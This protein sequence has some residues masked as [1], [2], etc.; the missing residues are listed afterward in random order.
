MVHDFFLEPIRKWLGVDPH[1]GTHFGA[2]GT[3]FTKFCT[4]FIKFGTSDPIAS[5]NP[6]WT[7]MVH[8]FILEPIRKWLGADPHVRTH[9]GTLGTSFT[10]FGTSFIKFGTSNLIVSMT[11][12]WTWMVCDFILEPIRKLLGANPYIR[13]HFRM[14]GTSFTK[15]GTCFIEHKASMEFQIKH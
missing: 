13:T 8:N 5:R 1:L 10:K 14:L 11:P 6:I 15:L 4:F 3:L 2:V 12:I 7:W 9:F